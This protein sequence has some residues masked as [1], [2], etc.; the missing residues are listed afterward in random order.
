MR[1]A[2]L[3]DD[4]AFADT[5]QD[6][7]IEAGYEVDCFNNGLAFLRQFNHQ[8]YDLCVFDWSLPDMEGPDVMTSIKLRSAHVPPIIFVTGNDNEADVVRVIESG[9]DDYMIKPPSRQ[10]FLARIQA[11]LRRTSQQSVV[12]QVYTFDTLTVD[13]KSRVVTLENIDIKLTD[14]EFD[15]IAYFLKNIGVLL[16]RT[17]LM[18]VV[19]GTSG[20]VETRKVDVHVSH[21]RTKLKLTPEFGWKMT[22][23][24]QQGYRLERNVH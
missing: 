4:K 22:S 18:Q 1:V 17:H 5:M 12:D 2:V 8:Q 7:L 6:W 23:I 9:A 10:V 16:S 13:T 3:E 20:E 19:W 15:L 11:I 24:Y 21:V 14:K